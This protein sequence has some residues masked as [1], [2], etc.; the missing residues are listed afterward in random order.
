MFPVSGVKNLNVH[1]THIYTLPIDQSSICPKCQELWMGCNTSQ[2]QIV[3]HDVPMNPGGDL[4][5]QSDQ[6]R[7]LSVANLKNKSYCG[8]HSLTT[9]CQGLGDKSWLG[10]WALH[11]C[12]LWGD[13]NFTSWE[14]QILVGDIKSSKQK[15]CCPARSYIS[16]I[17]LIIQ[18]YNLF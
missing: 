15:E 7:P 9:Q 18:F 17:F 11:Y 10:A 13:S 4:T 1:Y 14:T 12:F 5:Q 8:D 2:V 3:P 16:L 6:G